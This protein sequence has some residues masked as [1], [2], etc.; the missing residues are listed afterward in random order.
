MIRSGPVSRM[1]WREASLLFGR[2]R[3][4]RS[5]SKHHNTNK[6]FKRL[7]A[8]IPSERGRHL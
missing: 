4:F 8:Q 1:G 3:R 7:S 6:S 5:A 2:S